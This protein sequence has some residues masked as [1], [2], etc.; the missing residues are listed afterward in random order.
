LN[1]SS[2]G[3]LHQLPTAE[4]AGLW[5]LAWAR[6]GRGSFGLPRSTSSILTVAGLILE[7]HPLRSSGVPAE[8]A[9][10]EAP[11]MLFS[12]HLAR[13]VFG[14][15]P[16]D[17]KASCL[18][19]RS[20]GPVLTAPPPVCSMEPPRCKHRLRSLV[21]RVHSVPS[22]K[23]RRPPF[24]TVRRPE[25]RPSPPWTRACRCQPSDSFRPRGLSPPRRLSPRGRCRFV[26]PCCRPWGS[27]RSRSPHPSHTRR[28]DRRSSLG[29]RDA[30][31]PPK[32]FPRQKPSR[33]SAGSAP[34]PFL[35]ARFAPA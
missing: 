9:T 12:E 6:R 15:G 27:P 28:H 31:D 2:R 3:L 13:A 23:I 32:G 22:Q 24:A 19:V 21:P 7:V 18:P 29:P 10:P 4:V 25:S 34:L 35:L 26:A 11:L 1:Q 17:P 33:V 14:W 8:A 20:A 30:T 16:G 5:G